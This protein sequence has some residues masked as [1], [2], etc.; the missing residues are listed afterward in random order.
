ME[1]LQLRSSVFTKCLKERDRNDRRR[2]LRHES[3]VTTTF[4]FIVTGCDLRRVSC[5]FNN[6][7]FIWF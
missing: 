4:I 2:G 7:S 3:L 5:L 1:K 6:S